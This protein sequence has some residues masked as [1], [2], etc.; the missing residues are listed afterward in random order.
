MVS[1]GFLD[2]SL[3]LPLSHLKDLPDFF[4]GVQAACVVL[5]GVEKPLWD[6]KG[7]VEG[8]SQLCLPS[9]Q[10]ALSLLLYGEAA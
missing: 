1:V 6:G 5:T 10:T 7:A 3:T 8:G 4:M 9:L 2:V